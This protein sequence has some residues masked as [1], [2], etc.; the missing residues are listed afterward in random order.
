MKKIVEGE[1]AVK[2][3]KKKRGKPNERTKAIQSGCGK[4]EKKEKKLRREER[5]R[6]QLLK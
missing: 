2:R 1:D 3:R 6:V 5:E 4:K